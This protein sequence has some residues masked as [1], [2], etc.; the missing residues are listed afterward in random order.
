MKAATNAYRD[1]FLR[2]EGGKDYED[3]VAG[4]S[5]FSGNLFVR[6]AARGGGNRLRRLRQWLL[7]R[8]ASSSS[9]YLRTSLPEPWIHLG[10]G[11]LVSGRASLLL[12]GRLLGKAA[13]CGRALDS[14]ALLR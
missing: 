12:A 4:S 8:A 2:V 9:S 6:G 11:L 13:L 3:K 1:A 7:C 10:G 5:D 14:A